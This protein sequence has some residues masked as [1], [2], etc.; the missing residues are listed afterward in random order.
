M[1]LSKGKADWQAERSANPVTALNQ[2][3]DRNRRR[4]PVLAPLSP[5]K[6][7]WLKRVRSGPRSTPCRLI[8]KNELQGRFSEQCARPAWPVPVLA[9]ASLR[10][11]PVRASADGV[12]ANTATPWNQTHQLRGGRG[13]HPVSALARAAPRPLP[14]AWSEP[15]LPPGTG[16]EPFLPMNPRTRTLTAHSPSWCWAHSPA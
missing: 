13:P 4:G 7:P 8:P 12:R 3:Q 1:S 9:E 14:E 2:A 11:R 5:R 16:S 10:T 15:L 6:V